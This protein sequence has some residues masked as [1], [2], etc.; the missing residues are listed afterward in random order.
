MSIC[1]QFRHISEDLCQRQWVAD[2]GGKSPNIVC[3]LRWEGWSPLPTALK[4]DSHDGRCPIREPTEPMMF[5]AVFA[6]FVRNY[7]FHKLD[8]PM[9][10]K[11]SCSMYAELRKKS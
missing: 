10:L 1:P 9:S 2:L 5:Q 8:W 7:S 11:Y 4:E 6:K 3:C